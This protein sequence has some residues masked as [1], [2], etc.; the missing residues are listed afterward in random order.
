VPPIFADALSSSRLKASSTF[1]PKVIEKII[2]RHRRDHSVD[3]SNRIL[4]LAW[5]EMWQANG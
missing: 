4:S 3:F 2:A 1:C 5:F